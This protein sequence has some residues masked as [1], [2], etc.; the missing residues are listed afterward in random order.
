MKRRNFIQNIALVSAAIPVLSSCA[1]QEKKRDTISDSPQEFS[2]NEINVDQLQEKMKS[3]ELTSRSITEMYLN[4][5]DAVDKNG[6]TINSVI[7]L[8]A[9]ALSIADSLDAERKSGKV[10]GLLHGI[11]ILIKDNIDTAD[12]MMNT[13]GSIAM[14]GNLPS[15]DSF[16]V[17]KLRAAGAVILGKTNLS[18]WANFRSSQSTSGWS[19]RGGQTK[20]PYV[21]DRNPCGSSSGSGSAVAA[22]LCAIAIGTETDGS[23]IC[24]SSI[25]G[26]VG[27]KPTVGLCSRSGII[28]ISHTQDTPG[29]MARS[30]HDAAILLGAL[31]GVDELDSATK[32][33]EGKFLTDYT[34]FL[35]KNGLKGKRLG[36]EKSYLKGHQGVSDLLKNAVDQIKKQRAEIIEIDFLKQLES[37]GKDEFTVL[38][39]EFKEDLNKYL[40]GAKGKVKSLKELIEFN[41]QKEALA[42][43]WFKQDL[44]EKSEAKGDLKSKEYIDALNHSLSLTRKAINKT[45]DDNKL[46][47]ICG[48]SFGPSWCTDWVNGDYSTGYG[49]STPAAIA[50]YP[51]ITVPMGQVS[52]LP[53]GLSFFGKE[54]SEGSLVSLAYAYEQASMNRRP[55]EFKKS[56]LS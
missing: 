51:H 4:R 50:G 45:M 39:F 11:P 44:L 29:P 3:G 28:P 9:D 6:P 32:K 10:R 15:T 53:I 23:I 33:S 20:N 22:N 19:S 41:K 38:L 40:A 42:M 26:V 18:E 12:K 52:G 30:V 56:I 48:P 43:P 31:T 25:N 55:P 14:E 47:A 1:P 21:L 5:I 27:I 17:K 2:L 54:F 49:F 37:V 8:N 46:D 13:A 34:L 7:E 35:D 24:P 16:I 36:L